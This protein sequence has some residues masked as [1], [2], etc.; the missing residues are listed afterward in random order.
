[1]NYGN[2][3]NCNALLLK[4]KPPK[5]WI[6]CPNWQ[7]CKFRGMHISK[8]KGAYVK[9]E[10]KDITILPLEKPSK[11]QQD[12]FN[13]VMNG[14]HKIIK[15]LAGTGK[16]TCL[17]QV[18][19]ILNENKIASILCIAFAKRDKLVLEER[20][21]T[22][23]KVLTNNGA[24]HA[25]L[26]SYFNRY[27]LD[28]GIG[29]K[30]LNKMFKDDGLVDEDGKISI[31]GNI[32]QAILQLVE[33]ARG[34]LELSASGKK[35]PT[36]ADY[37]TLCGRF[38]IEIEAS[39]KDLAFQYA[40][41]LFRKLAGLEFAR[42][43][44]VDYAGQMFLPVYHN[45]HP[46]KKYKYI[47]VDETQDQS[48]T[49]RKMVEMYLEV[50]GRIIAVGDDNQ[51]IYGWR[52]ADS[53]AIN[54]MKGLME[55][56]GG[57]IE[58]FPLAVC[59]RCSKS[60]TRIAK[61]LV[62]EIECL[63]DAPEGQVD[64]IRSDEAFFADLRTNRKGLVLCR[65]NA[66]LI[67][68]CLKMLSEGIPSRMAK[69]DILT[70]LIRLIE[71]FSEYDDNC[72]VPDVLEAAL[73]WLMDSREKYAKRADGAKKIATAEDK[74]NCLNALAEGVKIQNAGDL[75]KKLNSM[76]P[77]DGVN[78][79]PEKMLVFSTVH[80]AKGG[81]ANTVYL[82]SP[83]KDKS[84]IW[85]ADWSGPVDRNNTLYVGVTRAENRLVFAGQ[86]PRLERFSK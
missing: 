33:K 63:D 79:T 40:S 67:S 52:G 35:E 1:M 77:E 75:K 36:S 85:D 80:G 10:L 71:Q 64:Y 49:N 55:T 69:S 54:L 86:A 43:N 59:R 53:E 39:Q 22:T 51:A 28:N 17:V 37:D 21:G 81:E 82:Y 19:R 27:T 30:T 42:V 3:P 5:N 46:N 13:A 45:I 72:S 56:V 73:V 12:I 14:C 60:V 11:E 41:L 58:E 47:L 7:S 78:N 61:L 66:P 6:F 26:A 2:C 25:I 70:D 68:T 76:F 38:D 44:G 84:C 83:E 8:A 65:M 32:I 18:V 50:G 16:T 20:L 15:A 24:G 9:T 23:A 57:E 48:Y 4:G 62:P 74:V 34:T 31:K 29:Y